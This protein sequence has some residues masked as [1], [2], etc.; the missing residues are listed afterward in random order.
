MLKTS[1]NDKLQGIEASFA[2]LP[3]PLADKGIQLAFVSTMQSVFGS[4]FIGGA[5]SLLLPA[6]LLSIVQERELRLK[7]M[8]R[9]NGGMTDT[10]YWGV[11]LLWAFCFQMVAYLWLWIVCLVIGLFYTKG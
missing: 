9:M 7:A 11:T 6:F 10:I 1:T 2:P 4:I 3:Y 5:M 8:M